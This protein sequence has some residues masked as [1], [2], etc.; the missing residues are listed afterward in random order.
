[1]SANKIRA[2]GLAAALVVWSLA[3]PRMPSRWHPVPHAVLG[4]ALA[5]AT[6][7]PLGLRRPSSCSGA[8]HGLAVAA[9]IA[10]GT[11]VAT[12]LR[13]VR[14]AMASRELPAAPVRWLAVGIPLGTVWFEETAYRGAL[15]ALATDA[16]GPTWGRLLQAAAFGLSHIADAR[17]GAV[18]VAPTVVVTGVA[19]WLFAWLAGRSGS[20]IAPMLAHLA[21]NEAGAVAA[22]TV[23]RIGSAHER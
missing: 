17:A 5:A 6:K 15:G 16:F 2:L 7:A 21:I 4:T 8:R 20:L 22:L 1:M 19:G 3:E 9:T 11:A 12:A 10:V 18:P 14:A 13:P 23:Q